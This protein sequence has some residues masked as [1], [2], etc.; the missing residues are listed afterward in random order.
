MAVVAVVSHAPIRLFAALSG[1]G[2]VPVVII[3]MISQLGRLQVVVKPPLPLLLQL[4]LLCQPRRH[5]HRLVPLLLER[6]VWST[7]L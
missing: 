2:V 3:A 5:S 6:P 4:R 7:A 1:A